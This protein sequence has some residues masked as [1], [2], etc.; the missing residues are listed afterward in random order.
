MSD[1]EQGHLLRNNAR[2]MTPHSE[3]LTLTYSRYEAMKDR[4]AEK[5]SKSGHILRVGRQLN[6]T[7]DEYRQ[8]I[9]DQLG[10]EQG[11][12]RC[13]YCDAIVD[14]QTMVTDHM[15]PLAQAGA[16]DLSNLC[17]ACSRDNDQKGAMT[18]HSYI[19]LL[20]FLKNRNVCS[21]VDEADCLGRLRTSVKLAIREQQ[22]RA[23]RAAGKQVV[24]AHV[25]V[26]REAS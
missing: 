13:F 9:R 7:I 22:R 1:R 3:F 26:R 16:L 21:E 20:V 15:Q 19:Q 25:R 18:A 2:V 6:F 14:L 4:V 24:V 8:W 11:T 5:R 12:A 10:G 17:I 23:Q